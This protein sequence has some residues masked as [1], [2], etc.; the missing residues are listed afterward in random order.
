MYGR[1]FDKGSGVCGRKSGRVDGWR[2]GKDWPRISTRV[3]KFIL[4]WLVSYCPRNGGRSLR[5][6]P[7]ANFFSRVGFSRVQFSTKR[8]YHHYLKLHCEDAGS[9]Y[10]GQVTGCQRLTPSTQNLSWCCVPWRSFDRGGT[11]AD[12]DGNVPSSLD[13]TSVVV[14]GHTLNPTL[15]VRPGHESLSC[16]LFLPR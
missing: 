12:Y 6:V 11:Y 3:G 5:P 15:D 4:V 8:Y 9:D 1:G 16:L 2:Q 13:Y 10:V 7:K 14:Q